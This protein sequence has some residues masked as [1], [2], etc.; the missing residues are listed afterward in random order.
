MMKKCKIERT[1][2]RGLVEELC[3]V[4]TCTAGQSREEPQSR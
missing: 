1:F 4:A 3:K 2:N